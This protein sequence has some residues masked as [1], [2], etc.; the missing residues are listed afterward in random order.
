MDDV[1]ISSRLIEGEFPPFRQIIPNTY[2]LKIAVDKSSLVVAVKRAGL[3]ARD[4]AN[5]IKI[6]IESGKLKVM[7]ENTQVG[8]NVTEVDVNTEGDSI[9]AFNTKYLLDYLSVVEGIVLW[10]QKGSLS[11]VFREKRFTVASGGY[12]D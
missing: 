2:K 6:E 1:E 12:A 11:C 4:L 8:K 5:V 7:S 10:R 9:M 3:F